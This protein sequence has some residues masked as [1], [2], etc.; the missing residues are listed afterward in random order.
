[1]SLILWALAS[2]PKNQEALAPL[3]AEIAALRLDASA[4]AP[5]RIKWLKGESGARSIQNSAL[6]RLGQSVEPLFRPL[7]YDWR[8]SIA[9]LSSL[10]AREVFVGTLGTLFA[11]GG[12]AE[13]SPGFIA[14]LRGA[15]TPEGAPRY[16]LATAVSL[17]LFFAVSLQCVSTIAIVRRE[18]G[19]WKWP[20]LQ[21]TAFFLIAYSL[22]WVGFN[23]TSF[24]LP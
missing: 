5:E 6:G 17:L 16:T 3:E 19:S 24:L 4:E 22:S 7:G 13:S 21:F 8:L 10:A 12:E 15:K 14:A 2:F 23:I 9:V 20:L 1:L 18:T 11:L